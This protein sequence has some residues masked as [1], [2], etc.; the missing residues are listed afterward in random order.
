MDDEAKLGRPSSFTDEMAER[1]C[2]EMASGRSLRSV[3]RDKGMPSD[4]TVF[5]WLASNDAFCQQYARA[6]EA[7]TNALAEDILDI[8]DDNEHDVRI[9]DDGRE[10]VNSDVI[11]RAK[12]RVDTRKWLMSKMAPKKYGEKLDMNVSGTLQTMP[13]E[14]IDARITQLLGK[15]G[16]G[17]SADGARSAEEPE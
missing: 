4:R 16:A 9:T 7:R 17:N 12:L 1:I 5:R 6:M 10:L 13:E 3:C 11:A 8:A 15:A 2:S 14:E